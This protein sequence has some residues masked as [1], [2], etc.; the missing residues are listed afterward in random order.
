[1]TKAIAFLDQPPLLASHVPRGR[2]EVWASGAFAAISKI[3]SRGIKPLQVELESLPLHIQCRILKDLDLASLVKLGTTSSYW[4]AWVKEYLAEPCLFPFGFRKDSPIPL[5]GQAKRCIEDLQE[6]IKEIK[7]RPADITQILKNPTLEQV[8]LLQ[9]WLEARKTLK[10]WINLLIDIKEKFPNLKWQVPDLTAATSQAEIEKAAEFKIWLEANSAFLTA[11]DTLVVWNGL[12]QLDF[13]NTLDSQEAIIDKATEFK[14]WFNDHREILIETTRLHIHS[15]LTSLPDEIG[16]FTKLTE[17]CLD[18]NYFT[19]LP[20]AI[21]K[22]TQLKHLLLRS[23]RI[24]A[25]PDEF[26]NL[27]QLQELSLDDNQLTSISN[28]INRFSHLM[29]LS[30]GRNLLHTLPGQIRRLTNLR[31]LNVSKNQLVKL[32]MGLNKLNELIELDLS[33]NHLMTL[34]DCS[35]LILLDTLRLQNNYIAS[36]P[37]GIDHFYRLTLVRADRTRLPKSE[38]RRIIKIIVRNAASKLYKQLN[39]FMTVIA[40]STLA[41]GAFYFGLKRI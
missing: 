36:L 24:S 10:A 29:F 8:P 2:W 11:R 30:L 31:S 21:C 35:Y 5:Y 1:M 25:L 12:A 41:L 16:E 28:K 19:E 14:D 13:L 22:L 20:S 9:K 17:L 39:P 32:P 7:D 18:R 40:A 6:V 27:T 15:F 3:F 26:Y 37:I 34:P 38:F 33:H 23:N 4:N